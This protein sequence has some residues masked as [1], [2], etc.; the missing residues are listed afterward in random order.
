MIGQQ[1]AQ[2]L[3]VV[4]VLGATDIVNAVQV[5]ENAGVIRAAKVMN[6]SRTTCTEMYCAGLLVA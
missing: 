5:A 4:R 6:W 2:Q 3:A 1:T